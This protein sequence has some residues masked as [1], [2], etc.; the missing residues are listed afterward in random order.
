MCA[1]NFSFG[2]VPG[3][4]KPHLV[5][6][7]LDLEVQKLIVDG[8]LQVWIDIDVNGSRAAYQR[9]VDFVA[10]KNLAYNL[11]S[12]WLPE[13]GGS[14]LKRV[15]ETLFPNDFEWSPKGRVA[16]RMPPQRIIIEIWPEVAP[17][18]V[19]NFVAL[20]ALKRDSDRAPSRRPLKL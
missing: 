2:A 15:K 18:A 5:S 12:N 1:Y 19:E 6:Q 10:A 17:L 8:K 11:T 16:V 3:C 9:A 14:E 7:M 13:L 20:C 4:V